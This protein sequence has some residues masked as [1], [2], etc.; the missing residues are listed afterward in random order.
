[1]LA[2]IVF[3]CERIC[4]GLYTSASILVNNPDAE[5]H[6]LYVPVSKG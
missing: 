4:N 3:E 1:M 5:L 2:P 6:L